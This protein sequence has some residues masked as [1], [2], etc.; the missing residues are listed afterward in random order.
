MTKSRERFFSLAAVILATTL[1]VVFAGPS[2]QTPDGA[3]AGGPSIDKCPMLPADNIWNTRVDQL[4]VD[5]N[6]AIYISNIGS[7]RPLHPDFGREPETGIPYNVV[8]G[9]QQKVSVRALS[10]ES[11]MGPAPIPENPMLEGG[12]DRHLAAG[13]GV[14]GDDR[15]A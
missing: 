7:D 15:Q 9:D 11:D 5:P 14:R 4:P 2:A 12:T 13:D 10:D 6:S 8:S 3:S 1:L